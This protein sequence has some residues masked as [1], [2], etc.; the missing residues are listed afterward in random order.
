MVSARMEC[1]TP[2]LAIASIY[3]CTAD[4]DALQ[5]RYNGRS[6]LVSAGAAV[7]TPYIDYYNMLFGAL[8][9]HTSRADLIPPPSKSRSLV[10]F[11]DRPRQTSW[12]SRSEIPVFVSRPVPAA[13]DSRSSNLQ[14]RQPV[15][16]FLPLL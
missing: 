12:T 6:L 11:T 16:P 15:W 14:L 1:G 10:R 2:S 3:A 5:N 7:L 13:L 8:W 9:L 4:H